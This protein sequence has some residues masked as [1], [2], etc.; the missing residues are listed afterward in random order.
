MLIYW[1]NAHYQCQMLIF[2]LVMFSTVFYVSAEGSTNCFELN[3]AGVTVPAGDIIIEYGKPLIIYCKLHERF[4]RKNNMTSENISFIRNNDTVLS[5]MVTIVNRTTAKL[6]IEKPPPSKSMYTCKLRDNTAAVCLNSVHVGTKPSNVMN[7]SCIGHNYENLT[8]S[9]I[10]PEHY[11][12]TTYNLTYIFP[13]RGH[14]GIFLCPSVQRNGN[15]YSCF[16]DITTSPHY[17][18]TQVTYYFQLNMTN[19]FGN[20]TQK[21][22]FDHFQNV[23][24]EPP[25]CLESKNKTSNSITLTWVVMTQMRNFPPGVS[26]RILYQSE[27]DNKDVWHFANTSMIERNKTPIVY[28]LTGLKYAHILYD[29]RVSMRSMKAHPDDQRM[30]SRPASI[31]VRTQNAVPGAPPKVNVG[32]FEILNNRSRRD[33][34]VYWQSIPGEMKNGE[35]FTYK[36]LSVEEDNVE[37][38]LEP[39]E[40]T[41]SYAKFDISLKSHRFI[42]VSTNEVGRSVNTSTI[43][44]PSNSNRIA[45]PRSFTKISFGNKLYELSWLHPTDSIYPIKNY[46][47]FFC[48]YDY[49]R[50]FQCKGY[51]EWTV[52]PSDKDPLKNVTVSEEK[53]YQFAISANTD[54]GSSGMVWASCTVMHDKKLTTMKSLWIDNI[55]SSFIVVGWKLDCS[56]R[57]GSIE[58]YVIYYCPIISPYDSTCKEKERN[59]TVRGDPH[60]SRGNITN[61]QSY[62]TYMVT[63]AVRSKQNIG[64]PSDPLYNTTLEGAPDPP[65]NVS[66]TNITSSSML[67]HWTRPKKMNGHL[68]FYKVEYSRNE[69]R[70]L[71]KP[72]NETATEIELKDLKSFTEYNITVYAYTTSQSQPSQVKRVRTAI[73]VPSKM[74]S[75]NLKF[76]NE[77]IILVSWVPPESPGGNLDNY[78]LNITEE[79][80]LRNRSTLINT[81]DLQWMIPNCGNDKK[82]RVLYF[83]IRAINYDEILNRRYVGEWSSEIEIYCQTP[84]KY[85]YWIFIAVGVI[86]L[87]CTFMLLKKL[88]YHCKIMRD[89]E[90]KLPPGLAPTIVNDLDLSNWPPPTIPKSSSNEDN[91]M[92]LRADLSADEELLL[93]KK[94]ELGEI[95]D[96]MASGDSSGCSSGHSSVTSSL[97]S[98]TNLSSSSDSGTGQPR[99]PSSESIS[100]ENS[101]RQRKPGSDSL[102]WDSDIAW[103]KAK[104]HYV[105]ALPV[106]DKLPLA[107]QPWSGLKT[108]AMPT[109]NY[110]VLGVPAETILPPAADVSG[111]TGYVPVP[112][113]IPHHEPLRAFTAKNPSPYVTCDSVYNND[114]MSPVTQ[115]PIKTPPYVKSSEAAIFVARPVISPQHQS[116]DSSLAV[117]PI[118]SPT[119][120]MAGAEASPSKSRPYVK[121]MDTNILTAATG[122]LINIEPINAGQVDGYVSRPVDKD[123]PRD[124]VDLKGV[125]EERS[126]AMMSPTSDPESN[127]TKGYVKTEDILRLK[128]ADENLRSPEPGM[129]LQQAQAHQPQSS[130]QHSYCRLGWDRNVGGEPATVSGSAPVLRKSVIDAPAAAAKGYVPHRQFLKED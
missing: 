76:P 127:T 67:V 30:W 64:L 119:Y 5:E 73:S 18:Q 6:Y 45:E 57:I 75:P 130:P 53:T 19:L 4:M 40:V 31:T 11:V 49:D 39:V 108:V 74:H 55:G 44:V 83:S 112:L 125:P 58:G 123:L 23:I 72:H 118:P 106:P 120:V 1:A 90:V 86:I 26:Y 77:S 93:A 68:R 22:T 107:P 88:W 43:F 98:G 115:S 50:P 82:Y 60:V 14:R 7:F 10:A 29:I 103:P 126:G 66:V 78:Q 96:R 65:E 109:S 21:Y 102:C 36:I 35:N 47:I 32:S 8:C 28:Q 104:S 124:I 33:I 101:L 17:R 85:W 48:R 117:T 37:K 56:D 97:A 15:E 9:W 52:V 114:K 89:V 71:L 13:G 2:A 113:N 91:S 70:H 38:N 51:L 59:M 42:I 128:T 54:Y 95:H 116:S 20:H 84:P 41:N 27:Y 63:V 25:E 87:G 121:A 100:R 24:P 122:K 79:I 105:S 69:F 92:H 16:W 61:L 99:T 94:A 62:T 80:D 34:Y 129:S 3:T 12:K 46:T 111:H 110:C 81:T